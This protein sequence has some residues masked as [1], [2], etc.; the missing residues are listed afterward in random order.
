MRS[1][2]L[3]DGIVVPILD[4]SLRAFASFDSVIDQLVWEMSAENV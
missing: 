2:P 1:E 3:T 4:D